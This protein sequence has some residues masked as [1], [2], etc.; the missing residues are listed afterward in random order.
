MNTFV[1]IVCGDQATIEQI[2][3]LAKS[4][5][6]LEIRS[7]LDFKSFSRDVTMGQIAALILDLRIGLRLNDSEKTLVKD[8]ENAIPLLRLTKNA[9]TQQINSLFEATNGSGMDFIA[10]FFRIQC[11]ESAGRKI[12]KEIRR[13]MYFN[14]YVCSEDSFR[15]EAAVRLNTLNVSATGMFIL[16]SESFP[17]GKKV[18]IQ[19]NDIPELKTIEA[20]VRW[21]VPWGKTNKIL[22]GYGV[23]FVG[24]SEE[25]SQKILNFR[26]Y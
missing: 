23:E 11:A 9:Q 18:Y 3:E 16:F 4:N 21:N 10:D 24:L 12:R 26:T 8:L 7:Y 15:A 22:A 13:E 5:T 14:I 20:V 25:D 17:Q 6:K 2:V 1:A 19:F